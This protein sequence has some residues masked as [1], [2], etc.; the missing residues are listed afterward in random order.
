MEEICSVVMWKA[1][2]LADTSLFIWPG[3]FK[4]NEFTQSIPPSLSLRYCR[5]SFSLPHTCV[6]IDGKK[7]VKTRI[8]LLFNSAALATSGPG[9]GGNMTFKNSPMHQN[10]VSNFCSHYCP[11]TNDKR[12]LLFFEQICLQVATN[13][14]AVLTAISFLIIPGNEYF[15]RFWFLFKD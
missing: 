8:F 6:T 1:K 14:A 13:I 12:A 3:V 10:A 2:L 7:F 15:S 5:P 11:Y 4:P 9:Y